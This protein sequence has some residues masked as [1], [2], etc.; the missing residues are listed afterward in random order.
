MTVRMQKISN[1]DRIFQ[2]ISSQAEFVSLHASGIVP[3]SSL[4]L[5]RSYKPCTNLVFDRKHWGRKSNYCYKISWSFHWKNSRLIEYSQCVIQE[6]DKIGL[7]VTNGA[8]PLLIRYE[9]VG[10]Y[11][12]SQSGSQRGY[13][14][15]SKLA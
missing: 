11:L 3:S 5:A 13:S 8:S 14:S 1:S 9:L 7:V 15:R 2:I 12:E 6:R 4:P 10:M